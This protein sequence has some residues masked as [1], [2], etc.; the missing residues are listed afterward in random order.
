[1]R[2]GHGRWAGNWILD[3]FRRDILSKLVPLFENTDIHYQDY[4][5][6]K[7]AKLGL[8]YTTTATAISLDWIL[9]TFD[10]VI[11]TIHTRLS[12]SLQLTQLFDDEIQAM[13]MDPSLEVS[14]SFLAQFSAELATRLPSSFDEIAYIDRSDDNVGQPSPAI[15]NTGVATEVTMEQQRQQQQEQRQR[16]ERIMGKKKKQRL[17]QDGRVAI[18][19]FVDDMDDEVVEQLFHGDNNNNNNNMNIASSSSS[20]SQEK[21][22]AMISNSQGGGGSQIQEYHRLCLQLDEITS[23]FFASK[24]TDVIVRMLY[25]QVD[26]KILTSF[27][28]KWNVPTLESG[29]EWMIQVVLPFLRLTLLPKKEIGRTSRIKRFKMWASRLEFY[30][31]KTFGDLRI[32]EFFDIVVECPRSE[33][34]VRDLKM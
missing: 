27:Q 11:Q 34:A 16:Q 33:P 23:S 8:K 22:E 15:P 29:K 9:H 17:M 1:M 5:K 19:L 21:V 24:M 31:F 3:T 25:R 2:E 6:E 30:F 20:S 10:N 13:R 28:S 7:N 32:K 26:R 12:I 14:A 18:D 4:V